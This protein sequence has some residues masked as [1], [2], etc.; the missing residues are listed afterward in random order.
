[1]GAACDAKEIPAWTRGTLPAEQLQN[2]DRSF[3][4]LV[5]GRIATETSLS[6][7]QLWRLIWG[8]L[9]Q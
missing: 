5:P 1:M 2:S 7:I 9:S 4:T 8:V 3:Q 6:G